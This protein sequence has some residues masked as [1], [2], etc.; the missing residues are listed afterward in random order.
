MKEDDNYEDIIDLPR[1]R[2]RNHKPMPLMKRAAQFAPFAAV[3]GHKEAVEEI[4]RLTECAPEEDSERNEVLN[5]KLSY[6]L[7]HR[8]EC[9]EVSIRYFIPDARKAGGRYETAV[10]A[11]DRV[12]EFARCLVM[13]DGKRLLLKH[14]VDIN[15]D[16]Q[17]E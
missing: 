17:G 2:P 16:M 12:D 13:A 5:R 9:P 8:N 1:P 7:A 15:V 10:G 6:I 3:S 11:V 14:I 4:N